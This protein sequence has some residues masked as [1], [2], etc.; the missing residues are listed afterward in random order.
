[1]KKITF[2]IAMLIFC[3]AVY[4]YSAPSAVQKNGLYFVYDL[5]VNSVII[6]QDMIGFTTD[7]V[8][9]PG[10]FPNEQFG[11]YVNAS[12]NPEFIKRVLA[13]ILTAKTTGVKVTI[14]TDYFVHP[15]RALDP[16]FFADGYACM[17]ITSIKLQ[18]Q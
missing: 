1:M 8:S 12:A 17:Q 11:A 14:T 4:S 16:D 18:N 2:I 9:A 13:T 6:K 5:P 15:Y 10:V 7:K 3:F